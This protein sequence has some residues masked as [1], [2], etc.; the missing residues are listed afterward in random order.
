MR[1]VVVANPRASRFRDDPKTL[2]D[3]FRA[4][5]DHIPPPKGDPAGTLQILIANWG[6]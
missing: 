6:A 4:I 2:E 3:L 1:F 5:A